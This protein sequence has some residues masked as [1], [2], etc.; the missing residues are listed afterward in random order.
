MYF[1]RSCC[2]RIRATAAPVAQLQPLSCP[3]QK[4]G[5]RSNLLDSK[6]LTPVCAT[7]PPVFAW[8]AEFSPP[9]NSR[10]SQNSRIQPQ[11]GNSFN[12]KEHK[13]HLERNLLHNSV[14]NRFT[15]GRVIIP[16]CS[17][18]NRLS[19]CSLR[20]LWLTAT[21]EFRFRIS[22]ISAPSGLGLA[23][24]HS[25]CNKAFAQWGKKLF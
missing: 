7:V 3:I 13:E 15:A 20:S 22:S 2:Y 9:S 25:A 4:T 19:L 5:P 12:H 14:R 24:G 1:I 11:N 18:C 16:N 10:T 8:D 23:E 17:L 21:A 6:K